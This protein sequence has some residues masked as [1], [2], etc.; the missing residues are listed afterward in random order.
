MIQSKS[1]P[2]RN[3]AAELQES[4]MQSQKILIRDYLFEAVAGTEDRKS[5]SR[6]PLKYWTLYPEAKSADNNQIGENL[7]LH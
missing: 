2:N 7:E 6:Y 3:A 1:Q 5:W 4:E